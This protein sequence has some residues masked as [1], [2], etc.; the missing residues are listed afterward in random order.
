M[1]NKQLHLKIQWN[2][3]ATSSILSWDF[4]QLSKHDWLYIAGGLAIYLS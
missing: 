1:Q 3:K 2:I 4:H